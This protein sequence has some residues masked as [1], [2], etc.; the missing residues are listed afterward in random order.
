MLEDDVLEFFP[1]WVC[2]EEL[3]FV[4][5]G[6]AESLHGFVESQ[7]CLAARHTDIVGEAVQCLKSEELSLAQ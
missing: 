2:K 3:S 4:D 7:F 5:D 6:I 1:V